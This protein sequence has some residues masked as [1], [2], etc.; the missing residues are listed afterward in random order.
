M[1][2]VHCS[3]LPQENI[4]FPLDEVIRGGIDAVSNL[5]EVSRV[6]RSVLSFL[7]LPFLG[8]NGTIYKVMSTSVV[9]CPEKQLKKPTL[10]KA[11]CFPQTKLRELG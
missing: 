10:R 2:C 8:Q 4:W 3:L 11:R 9:L 7:K 1:L 5:Q 6:Y